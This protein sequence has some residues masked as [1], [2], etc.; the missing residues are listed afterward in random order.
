MSEQYFNNFMLDLETLGKAPN[1]PIL[2]I[3]CVAFNPDAGT[4][5][6]KNT[7][8]FYLEL[9]PQFRT[10]I[11]PNE[12]TIM[13]WLEQSEEARRAQNTAERGN[14]R[15]VLEMFNKWITERLGYINP[16]DIELWGNGSDFDV[17]I[18]NN[19]MDKFKVEPVYPFWS[20][21]CLRTFRAHHGDSYV[22]IYPDLAH[23]ALSDAIAQARS[24]IQTLHQFH[25]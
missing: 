17:T 9:D 10:G 21:R 2:S 18:L 14:P 12:S 6:T 7:F 8:H 20:G 25:V 24:V 3:G 13:W 4:I 19:L 11:L 22:R 5:D 23:D 15:L 1:S 16:G